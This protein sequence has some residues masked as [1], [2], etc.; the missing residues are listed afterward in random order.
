M[1]L[2]RMPRDGQG[3]SVLAVVLM[4]LA[5]IGVTYPI[6]VLAL[7]IGLAILSGLYT[8]QEL[9]FKTSRVD[10]INP[11]S[12]FNRLWLEYIEEFGDNDEMIIIVEGKSSTAVTPILES[13]SAK[14]KG[15]PNLFHSVMYGVDLTKIRAKGLHY[16]P[17]K[18]LAI[19]DGFVSEA[20][21]ILNGNWAMLSVEAQLRQYQMLLNLRGQLS[22]LP[23]DVPMPQYVLESLPP[24]MRNVDLKAKMTNALND[25]DAL[26]IS[27]ER[28]LLNPRNDTYD[29][30]WQKTQSNMSSHQMPDVVAAASVG[31]SG[32]FL[33][34]TDNGI[35]GFVMLRLAK[36]EKKGFVHGTEAI[37]KV[38]ELITEE[39]SHHPE[40]QIGL[41]GMIVIENDEMRGSSNAM[42][43]ASILSLV[44]VALVFMA[45]FGGFRHPLMAVFS[46][47]IAFTWTM[48]YVTLFIGHLNILSVS[49]GSILIGLG[50]DF[51]IHYVARYMTER[52]TQ[53]SPGEAIVQAA[54][55]VGP[56]V[57]TGAV[58][59]AIAFFMAGL[60]EFTGV[61]ELGIIS[62]GGVLLCCF[63]TLML[64]PAMIMLSDGARP[65]RKMPQQL[66]VNGF[67]KP[68]FYF[69]RTVIA[70][71]LVITVALL[72][73]L[74]YVWYDHNLL[75][76][77][78][79]GEE[80]VE[81][82]QRILNLENSGQNVWYALSIA[83]SREQLL[84]RK[85]EFNERYPDLRVDEI[86][87]WFP[88]ADADRKETI[89]RIA[90]HLSNLPAR[91]AEDIPVA[92][93][94]MTIRSL[95]GL[96]HQLANVPGTA[97]TIQ[98]LD[99][100]CKWLQTNRSDVCSAHIARYQFAMA[101]D[102]LARMETLRSM[103]NP[104]SP[105][106]DDLPES[107][108]SR[109]VS[110]NGK[111]LMRIFT[112]ADIWNMDEMEQFVKQVRSID[113]NATGAPLQT[114]EA[115]K[116]MQKGYIMTAIYAF[117]AVFV[118][119]LIDMRSLKLTLLTLT[120]ML[121][122]LAQTFGLLGF[123]GV[124]LNP[125]NMIVLP[126]I[127]G[128]GI[129]YGVHIIH[130]YR[131]RPNERYNMSTSTASAVL[132]TALTTM[133]GF[134]TLMIASH[135]GLQSLGRVLVI[136]ITC[137]LFTSLIVLPSVLALFTSR[138]KETVKQDEQVEAEQEALV[139][140]E[141]EA[142]NE[143]PETIGKPRLVI[144]EE[145]EYATPVKK[146]RRRL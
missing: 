72:F 105:T 130:D 27:L 135:R 119:L 34:P 18:D 51:G 121:I 30:P 25:L 39:R 2:E 145:D 91:P 58:T 6:T 146:L 128:I 87:S 126:L 136:G 50:V 115:S 59:T 113:A 96:E 144:A 104:E 110:K 56:G 80:S 32:Y 41:T 21:P 54:G 120:P 5:R 86:V 28:S 44:G 129:D 95:Q 8:Y 69:P 132:I 43:V 94:T 26:S 116:Q 77:Q 85:A 53:R 63:A 7:A 46:L 106:I 47:V 55:G 98:R 127:I 101:G 89:S 33:V 11:N 49:F 103:A 42:I 139:E 100:I 109:F 122:G 71:S 133:L 123:L 9:G 78:A 62:G 12:G 125:A 118:L 4:V 65:L 66:N 84:R 111:F 13:V 38:R 23:P 88:E 99:K 107:L 29:S 22:A 131:E 24:E 17:S 143:E 35:L 36:V 75:H 141:G 74:P 83:D 112:D 92:D 19:I 20:A 76:L 3:R 48:G 64:I 67:L 52:K 93:A 57:V 14:I 142:A 37:D 82:E 81:W 140:L 124:P 31:E 16:V 40:V 138:N 61:A 1:S 114:Y 79:D 102:L 60:A 45:G 70:V 15:Y 10:L 108:V 68:L 137:T 97:A 90:S 73:G 134:G 117:A